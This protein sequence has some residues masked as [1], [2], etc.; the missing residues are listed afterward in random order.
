MKDGFIQDF[1]LFSREGGRVHF[2]ANLLCIRELTAVLEVLAIFLP[3]R[4]LITVCTA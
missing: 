1:F 3:P 2:S 4:V